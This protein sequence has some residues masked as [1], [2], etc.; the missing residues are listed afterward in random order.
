MT[1]WIVDVK[2]DQ[3]CTMIED[4]ISYIIKYIVR[5]IYQVV[6]S[7][8]LNSITVLITSYVAFEFL[9]SFLNISYFKDLLVK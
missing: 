4:F 8:K 1:E 3:R 2:F 6:K 5:D 9:H 7:S